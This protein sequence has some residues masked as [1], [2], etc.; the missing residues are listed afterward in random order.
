[1][2]KAGNPRSGGLAG[3]LPTPQA[4]SLLGVRLGLEG[5]PLLCRQD[6][7]PVTFPAKV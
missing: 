4:Q 5:R 7:R 2:G 1:M 6:R 3:L